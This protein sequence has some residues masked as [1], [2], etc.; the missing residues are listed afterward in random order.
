MADARRQII[1]KSKV[2]MGLLN[3]W[4]QI[5]DPERIDGTRT[6]TVKQRSTSSAQLTQELLKSENLIEGRVAI[7]SVKQRPG[8]LMNE[9][10]AQQSDAMRSRIHAPELAP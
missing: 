9:Y 4:S 5:R 7:N 6:I 8:G 1:G 3:P 10:V 2:G